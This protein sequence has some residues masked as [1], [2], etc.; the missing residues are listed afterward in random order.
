M[1]KKLIIVGVLVVAVV[2]VYFGVTM[3]NG[4]PEPTQSPTASPTMT[5]SSTPKVG[6]CRPTGCSGQICADE[7]V[8]TTCE[9]RPEYA[10]YG[11]ARCERQTNGRCGWTMTPELQSC[12]NRL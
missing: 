3:N 7:D 11:T 5:P 12:L 8:V 2:A 10:C 1:N 9:F 4:E 6:D